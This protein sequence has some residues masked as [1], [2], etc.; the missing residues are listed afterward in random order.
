MSAT[1]GNLGLGTNTSVDANFDISATGD[2]QFT[3]DF[4]TNGSFTVAAPTGDANITGTNA[5]LTS[6]TA[7]NIT[8]N[9]ADNNFGDVISF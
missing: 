8:L 6:V 5:G 7:G 1:N 2:I 3:A 4:S 9:D